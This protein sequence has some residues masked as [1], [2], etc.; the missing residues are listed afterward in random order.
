M[1]IPPEVELLKRLRLAFDRIERILV[2][3]KNVKLLVSNDIF[4]SLYENGKRGLYYISYDVDGEKM[5]SGG[6]LGYVCKKI[7]VATKYA[8][9][10]IGKKWRN[11]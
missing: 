7:V 8:P 1:P 9:A 11:S 5:E 10:S 6:T 3:L 2:E 4:T